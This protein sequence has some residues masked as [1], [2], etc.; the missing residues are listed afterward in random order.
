MDNQ[1]AGSLPGLSGNQAWG[2]EL[3]FP[4]GAG[5]YQLWA[6]AVVDEDALNPVVPLTA[7][8]P[9]NGKTV[10]LNGDYGEVTDIGTLYVNPRPLIRC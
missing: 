4:A 9:A 1:D 3:R 5:N 8:K 10:T 2:F 7:L 6:K